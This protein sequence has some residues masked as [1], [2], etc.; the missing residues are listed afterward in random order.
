MR[1][2]Q[3][4][5][6]RTKS[7]VTPASV[8]PAPI[9]HHLRGVFASRLL[10]AAVAHLRV[11]EHVAAERHTL[12]S[13]RHALQLAERP[14]CVLFPS[15]RAMGLLTVDATGAVSLTPTGKFLT[16]T[17]PCHLIDYVGLEAGDSGVL[18][19]VARLRHDGPLSN[20]GVAFVKDD[21]ALSPMD[22]PHTARAFTLALAGRARLL[23]PLAARA[24]P[25]SAGHLLDVASGTGFFTY[26]WLR[27]NPQA[28]ATVLDRPA[29]LEVARELL[30]EFAT[31]DAAAATVPRRV[32]FLPGDMLQDALP[33]ADV[34]LAA[35]VFH[36]WPE[37]V[38]RH[39]MQRF[40][41]ALPT[42]GTLCIHDSFLNDAMD[43]PLAMTDYSTQLFW[44]TKGRL[45]S[46]AEFRAWMRAAGLLPTRTDT[47]TLMDYALITATQS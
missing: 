13:L 26:E 20:D 19:M 45:Y 14:A 32:D 47:P 36:D 31:R 35:S 43:G 25:A 40:A 11:F 30:R 1:L 3:S 24:M 2:P 41:D 22:V 28:R 17:E 4:Q 29:V 39:L 10:V 6:P 23:A 44:H 21:A 7:P 37:A 16:H 18:E 15:L 27:A 46:R 8:D 38:C 42:G 12:E 33:R 9:V 5:G 34:I